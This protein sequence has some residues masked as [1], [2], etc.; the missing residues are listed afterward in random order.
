MK[1]EDQIKQQRNFILVATRTVLSELF[2]V[3]LLTYFV[4]YVFENLFPRT[5][6]MFL[7][8]DTL[9]M[10]IIVT[11]VGAAATMREEISH[12]DWSWKKGFTYATVT[13]IAL[14]CAWI[15]YYKLQGT[16]TLSYAAAIGTFLFVAITSFVMLN[17]ESTE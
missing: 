2:K 7:S 3:S 10:V 13:M 8:L 14:V 6:S 9:A 11:A 4:L 15:V 12:D 5:I 16:G 17:Q 1:N